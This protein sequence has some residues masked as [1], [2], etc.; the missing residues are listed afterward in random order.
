LGSRYARGYDGR[1]GGIRKIGEV[2]HVISVYCVQ[3]FVCSYYVQKMSRT[4]QNYIRYGPKT[5]KKKL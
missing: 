1:L 2:I 3:F 4:R 5:I